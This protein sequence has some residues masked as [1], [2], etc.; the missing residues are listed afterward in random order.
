M[1]W[2]L[3]KSVDLTV[4]GSQSALF[5]L[6]K[7][8]LVHGFLRISRRKNACTLWKAPDCPMLGEWLVL[9]LRPLPCCHVEWLSR[10]GPTEGPQR[11]TVPVSVL[12]WDARSVST[13]PTNRVDSCL[14]FPSGHTLVCAVP[15]MGLALSY[16]HSF[17]TWWRCL[18]HGALPDHTLG[19]NLSPPLHSVF[20]FYASCRRHCNRVA[21]WSSL[22]SDRV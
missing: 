14:H 13:Y 6:S 7:E 2:G 21:L 9:C 12:A 15:Q 8:T 5:T 4:S 3:W 20:P 10:A 16:F 1:G 17:V 18:C 19:C 11:G 22:S